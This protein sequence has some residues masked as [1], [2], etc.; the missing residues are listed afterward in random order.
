MKNKHKLRKSENKSININNVMTKLKRG[1]EKEIGKV[2]LTLKRKKGVLISS[3]INEFIKK[4]LIK[5]EEYK[6]R[7]HLKDLEM[8]MELTENNKSRKEVKTY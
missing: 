8:N 4:K 6:G 2:T 3:Q 7:E 1:K 5:K